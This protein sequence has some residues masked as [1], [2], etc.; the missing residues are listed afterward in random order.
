MKHIRYISLIA[1]LAC[2]HL[3]AH[4]QEDT[5]IRRVEFRGYVKNMQSL[6]WAGPQKISLTDGFL[7]NRLI[8]KYRPDTS[9]TMDIEVRNRLFYGEGTRSGGAYYAQIL[10]TD[11]GIWDGA[12]VVRNNTLIWS[13][14]I[15]RLWIE[16]TRAD[17]RVRVGRQRINW[18]IA[19]IWTP[20]DLFNAWNF[21]DFDYEERPGTD[22][23]LIQ[24]QFGESVTVD[25]ALSGSR[26]DSSI[27]AAM[28]VSANCKEYDL[29]WIA[30]LYKGRPT[31]GMGWAGP[32]GQFGFK[33]EIAW[34]GSVTGSTFSATMQIDRLLPHSWYISTGVLYAGGASGSLGQPASLATNTLAP[35]R[36]MPVKWSAIV[37]VV[38]PV[39]PILDAS[40]ALVYSPEFH[41]LIAVPALAYNIREDWDIDLTGQI[42]ML[43]APGDRFRDH[44]MAAFLRL[45]HSF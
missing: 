21:L 32:L 38:K 29:Q 33:G 7:H 35:D 11:N 45:R 16:Y 18:G 39:T 37:S 25:A 44:Y 5:T 28:R 17:W 3:Q 27:V 42:F 1:V 34:F 30:G 24:K 8:F 26:N 20:N 2:A 19:T 23:I 41:L 43:Q 12:Y 14:M 40:M 31:A 10:D 9:W 36:L 6:S 15:D 22:A 13:T 4:A